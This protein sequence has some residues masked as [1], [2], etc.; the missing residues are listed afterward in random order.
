MAVEPQYEYYPI[1]DPDGIRLIELQPSVDPSA[2]LKCSL[3]HTKLSL[4]DNRDIFG[5]YTALSYV[6][7]NPVKNRKLFVDGKC[8]GITTNLCS[9]LLDLRDE[10]RSL[11]LWTD[12]ICI[13]QE[14]DSEK[15]TQVGLMG[16]IYAGALHT[17]IYLGPAAITDPDCKCLKA[18]Q[19][20]ADKD[21]IPDLEV[22]LTKEWF[23]RVWVFQELVFS[24][25]PWLQCGRIRVKWDMLF[26]ALGLDIDQARE[27]ITFSHHG[28]PQSYPKGPD[29]KYGIIANMQEARKYHLDQKNKKEERSEHWSLSPEVG[30]LPAVNSMINL[31]LS[32]RGFGATDPRD[33]IFSHVGFASDGKHELFAVNY[34]KTTFE[35]FESAA[36]YIAQYHG[37]ANLLHCRGVDACSECLKDLP[38]WVPDWT[39]KISGDSLSNALSSNHPRISIIYHDQPGVLGCIVD[40]VDTI[41][42]I[43]STLSEQQLPTGVRYRISSKLAALNIKLT[44]ERILKML[45]EARTRVQILDELW[46]EAYHA[47]SCLVQN[48]NVLPFKLKDV[49]PRLLDHHSGRKLFERSS[50][51]WFMI[52]A[53]RYANGTKFVDGQRLARMASGRLA[54]VPKSTYEGDIVATSYGTPSLDSGATSYHSVFRSIQPLAG[55]YKGVEAAAMSHFRNR[56]QSDAIRSSVGELIAAGVRKCLYRAPDT[57]KTSTSEKK[58]L[59]CKFTGGCFEDE[60]NSLKYRQEREWDYILDPDRCVLLIH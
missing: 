50:E 19:D 57:E 21:E 4:C 59:H 51:H 56:H 12:G 1:A 58:F 29:D 15:A 24:R 55:Y 37:V 54:L 53:L 16:I 45:P 39:S 36:R 22:I 40:E 48:N 11:L 9:A 47:W 25:C 28:W 41:V 31:L 49:R 34:S 13:N 27:S 44:D 14:D 23:T 32:R 17:V 20:G 5:H 38:S 10:Q 3:M 26:N 7:G 8:L 30:Y 33:M 35:V 2:P 6:W 46:S 52:L 60:Q 18:I 42:S 43:S